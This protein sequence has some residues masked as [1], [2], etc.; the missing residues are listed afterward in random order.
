VFVDITREESMVRIANKTNILDVLQITIVPILLMVQ[1]ETP[2]TKDVVD[3]DV[4]NVTENI[5]NGCT[6]AFGI[7]L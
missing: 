3:M 7:P 6:S 1:T 2:A 4:M 5:D